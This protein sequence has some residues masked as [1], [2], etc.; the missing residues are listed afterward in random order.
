MTTPTSFD[1]VAGFIALLATVVGPVLAHYLGA[2]AVII[3]AAC[4]GGGWSLTRREPQGRGNAA[5][6]LMLV[7]GTAVMVTAGIAELANHYVREGIGNWLL[8]PIALG[9]GAVGHDWPAVIKW[10]AG[11]ILRRIT[12]EGRPQ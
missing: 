7:A 4:I 11:P 8:A 10:A 12:G 5:L 2:Y 9:I 3:L 1:P 6:F